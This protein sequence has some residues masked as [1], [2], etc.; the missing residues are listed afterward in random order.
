MTAIVTATGATSGGRPRQTTRTQDYEKT[1]HDKE[2]GTGR[3]GA[4]GPQGAYG[5]KKR[6]RQQRQEQLLGTAA[7]G[8]GT[9]GG[10]SRKITAQNAAAAM[11]AL[12][13]RGALAKKSA[14]LTAQNLTTATAVAWPAEAYD[15]DSIHDLVTNN[16]RLTVPSGVSYVRLTANL[17]LANVTGPRLAIG[18]IPTFYTRL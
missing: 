7:V 12:G 4:G 18:P 2:N 5:A 11:K 3:H 15:T 13:V 16:S 1:R 17:R 9:A 6:R 10:N 14:D 8:E